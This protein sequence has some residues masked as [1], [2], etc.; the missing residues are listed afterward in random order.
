VAVSNVM[1]NGG[2]LKMEDR[3]ARA[4]GHGAD[5]NMTY[6]RVLIVAIGRINAADSEN[7]GLLLRNLFKDWPPENL[8]Q[9]YSSGD[10]GDKGC[11]GRYYRLSPKDRRLGKIFYHVKS[12][13]YASS[14]T[15]ISA[16]EI[17][18]NSKR[19][20]FV[21]K[22][23]FK[24]LFVDTGIYELVFRPRLSA[25]MIRWVEDFKPDI[26]FAQGY[27]LTFVWLPILIKER[28]GTKLAF[29]ATD[30]WP[31]YLY[32]GF[33]GG[34]KM[35]APFMKPTVIAATNRLM[36]AVDIPF[37]FGT[38]MA[39]EYRRRYNKEF[40]V[41]SHTDDSERFEKSR[42]QRSHP[43]GVFTILAMGNY[44]KFRWP[45]LLD[46]NECCSL[47]NEEGIPI[48]LAVYCYAIDPEG[49]RQIAQARYIDLFEDPGNASLPSFLK[50]ADIL[51]L[52]EAFDEGFV[53]AI[54]LS[55]SSKSHLFMFSRR[56]IIVYAHPETGVSRYAEE[57][58]WART[59][60]KRDVGMLR[61]TIRDLLLNRTE[62]NG[63]ASSAEQV[64]VRFHMN[65]ANRDRFLRLLTDS[66]RG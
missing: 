57:Y 9:I 46:I 64:A 66:Y 18:D 33:L 45:L 14:A 24:R 30:D 56:P 20:T 11:F 5:E 13:A 36:A 26:V 47:L 50:G 32:S 3:T 43:E 41:L 59:I 40:A 7:N 35:F 15:K 44:N 48:R 19:K 34:P 16:P 12:V 62:S 28:F 60:T 39:E 42:P 29:L 55:V 37:A 10:N 61:D 2:A 23:W 51:L 58:H 4:F 54:R 65:S 53:S 6:P 49:A 22:Q 63:L 17:I 21:L 31:T 38:P 27:C 52:A 25:E 8:A 1:D